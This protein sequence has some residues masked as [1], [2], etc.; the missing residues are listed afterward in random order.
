VTSRT[1]RAQ[2]RHYWFFLLLTLAAFA[3][4][5]TTPFMLDDP[6]LIVNNPRIHEWTVSNLQGDFT[7][8]YYTDQSGLYYRPLQFMY[9]RT[10]YSLG[11]LSPRPYHLINLLVQAGNGWLV[12]ALSL[13]LGTPVLAA[14][15]AGGFYAIHPIA[16]H[17]LLAASQTDLVAVFFLLLSLYLILNRHH[18]FRALGV[19]VYALGLLWKESL[20]MLPFLYG[21]TLFLQRKRK[22]Q[23]YQLVTP[24]F[25]MWGPYWAARALVIRTMPDTSVALGIQFMTRIFPGVLRHYLA[26]SIAPWGLHTWPDL[27][28]PSQFWP[29]DGV[30][31]LMLLAG[32]LWKGGFWGRWAGL[33]YLL[34]LLPKIPAMMV[35]NVMMD[36]WIYASL[37]GFLIPMALWI[38]RAGSS[39]SVMTKRWIYI[40]MAALSLGWIGL[41]QWNMA[42]RGSDE[43]NLRWSL[44]FHR[45]TFVEYRLAVL[46][47]G[48]GRASEAL[49]LLQSLTEEFSSNPDFGNAYALALWRT[50]RKAEGMRILEK[51]LAQHPLYGPAQNNLADM[52]RRHPD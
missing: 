36:H 19:L 4:V 35:N 34:T 40:L 10:M 42:V 29:W 37:I 44:R 14:M 24:L 51:I 28:R 1:P 52:K 15:L 22:W 50:G 7:R 3:S 43:K 27:P 48:S 33:W 41:S 16:V 49:P 46:L 38:E 45:P 32:L 20:V 8:P 2:P 9:L 18:R 39:G 25:L 30:A 6:F 26:I 31:L 12:Y 23:D 11:G 13:L 21:A 17:E 5:W 47:L